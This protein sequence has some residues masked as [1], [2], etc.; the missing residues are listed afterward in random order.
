M[1]RNVILDIFNNHISIKHDLKKAVKD[2]YDSDR[3][4]IEYF[5][6]RFNVGSNNNKVRNIAERKRWREDEHYF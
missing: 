4:F 5:Y 1:E 3:F 2:T 6:P